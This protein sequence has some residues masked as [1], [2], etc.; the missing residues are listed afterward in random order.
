M[1]TE[2]ENKMTFDEYNKLAASTDK[3]PVSVKPWIYALGLTGEAGEVSDKL[4][5][6]YRD[7]GGVISNEAKVELVKELGDVMWYITRLAA[8]LGYSLCEVASM[9]V[10]KLRSR[11]ERGAIHGEGDNR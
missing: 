7:N 11:A 4:K 2:N 5:K 3:Y 1:G 8:S 6:Q 10:E 9:N